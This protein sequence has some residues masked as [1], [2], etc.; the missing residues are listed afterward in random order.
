M[1]LKKQLIQ[2]KHP[3]YVAN[4]W[5]SEGNY[6]VLDHFA[7]L[8]TINELQINSTPIYSVEPS[9]LADWIQRGSINRPLRKFKDTCLTEAISFNN[10]SKVACSL[11][12]LTVS[13]I[14]LSSQLFAAEHF[15]VPSVSRRVK[16]NTCSLH[17]FGVFDSDEDSAKYIK[18]LID[19]FNSPSSAD[20]GLC[21]DSDSTDT[22][23][24]WDCLN[25]VFFSFD[26]NF[27][28]NIESNIKASV[29]YL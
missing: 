6:V 22:D 24:W 12:A 27:L 10:P 5:S 14:A 15:S 25:N 23:V 26:R 19:L 9:S 3:L 7:S 21:F 4:G 2:D 11:S 18:S 28:S 1:K 20:A 13:V 16:D 29:A 17:V 8:R